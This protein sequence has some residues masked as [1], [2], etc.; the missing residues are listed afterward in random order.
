[1][2]ART[3]GDPT[4]YVSQVVYDTERPPG[5]PTAARLA[6]RY[7]DWRRALRAAD[8]LQPDGRTRGPGAPWPH[9][10]RAT[11]RHPPYS[12]AEVEAALRAYVT[13]HDRV[14]TV[15]RYDDWARRERATARQRGAGRRRL[16][17]A[18]TIYRLYRSWPR[19]LQACGLTLSRGDTV[20]IQSWPR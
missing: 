16:P 19:A 10:E 2:A 17:S 8:G 1:V 14:P 4:G 13:A 6:R 18:Q 15:N 3:S 7:G 12:K 5:S 11:P 20:P 9:T